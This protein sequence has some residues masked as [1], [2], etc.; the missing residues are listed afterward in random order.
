[1]DGQNTGEGRNKA[2]PVSVSLYFKLNFLMKDS[3]DH[4]HWATINTVSQLV[5]TA[6]TKKQK[7]FQRWF[8]SSSSWHRT[9]NSYE[10]SPATKNLFRRHLGW[11][12]NKSLKFCFQERKLKPN[13]NW[14]WSIEWLATT[15]VTKLTMTKSSFLS[16]LK[17][18]LRRI[19]FI[20]SLGIL[21]LWDHC[22]H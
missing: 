18:K 2:S 14:E 21:G 8:L 9:F 3:T 15:R 10:R 1:M 16:S 12:Q 17:D 6:R 19:F 4:K 7:R 20:A 13:V 22:F 11:H 5:L